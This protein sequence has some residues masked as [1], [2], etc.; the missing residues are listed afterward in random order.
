MSSRVNPH[1]HKVH[2][3]PLPLLLLLLLILLLGNDWDFSRLSETDKLQSSKY[4]KYKESIIRSRWRTQLLKRNSERFQKVK[5]ER[6]ENQRGC[7]PP[8]LAAATKIQLMERRGR[9][10]AGRKMSSSRLTWRTRHGA[11]KQKT[12]EGNGMNSYASFLEVHGI[13]RGKIIG[14]YYY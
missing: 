13:P 10:C 12:P 8:P 3:V 11:G 6:K 14:Q 1:Y 5:T 4:S 7:H 9:D 2:K